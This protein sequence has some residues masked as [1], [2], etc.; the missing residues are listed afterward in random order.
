MR[1]KL[2]DYK[3]LSRART[4]RVRRRST[5]FALRLEV[6]HLLLNAKTKEEQESALR[7]YMEESIMMAGLLKTPYHDKMPR[8][9]KKKEKQKMCDIYN[10]YVIL[11][12]LLT[13]IL[14]NR[15]EEESK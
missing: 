11:P 12:E 2:K 15:D 8:K 13:F 5:K 1:F 10:A 9:L 4:L 6:L 7:Q 3:K 14:N